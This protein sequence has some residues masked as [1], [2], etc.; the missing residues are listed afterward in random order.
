MDDANKIKFKEI[1]HA[2]YEKDGNILLKPEYYFHWQDFK[3]DNIYYYY[4]VGVRSG[5]KTYDGLKWLCK[6]KD[7]IFVRRTAPEFDILC[8]EKHSPF[9]PL[10]EVGDIESGCVKR[11]KKIYK[12]YAN[13]EWIADGVTLNTFASTRSADYT[14]FKNVFWDEFI[15]QPD[16]KEMRA[17]GSAWMSMIHTIVRNRSNCLIVAA[18]NSNDIY[19]PVFKELGVINQLERL[20][21]DKKEGSKIYTDYKRHIKIV[22]FEPCFEL[23]K[24]LELTAVHDLTEGTRYADMAFNNEFIANDFSDTGYKSIKGY[25]PMLSIDDFTIW[26]KKGSNEIYISYAS[27]EGVKQYYSKYEIDQENLRTNYYTFFRNRYLK[28]LITFESYA[29]KRTFLEIMK[30]I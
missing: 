5:G 3:E 11:S 29:I 13:D 2:V 12:L 7:G 19:N 6:V 20:M 4:F 21:N 9:N 8:D 27:S 18:A 30:L 17:E 15:K 28:H 16:Q 26:R 22:L 25:R 10:I 1:L 24:F 23:K 14:L